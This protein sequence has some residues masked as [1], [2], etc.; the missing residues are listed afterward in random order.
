MIWVKRES[1]K[2]RLDG[3]DFGTFSKKKKNTLYKKLLKQIENIEMCQ[4]SLRFLNEFV[5]VIITEIL[6]LE[7][8]N[9]APELGAWKGNCPPRFPKLFLLQFGP[10]LTGSVHQ[11]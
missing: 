8:G 2:R 3:I 9:T 10:S 5:S 4:I 7:V 6:T 1:N 11:T